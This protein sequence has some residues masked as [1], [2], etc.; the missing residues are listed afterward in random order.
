[1]EPVPLHRIGGRTCLSALAV[2]LVSC[3]S[4][5]SVRLEDFV[6]AYD[7][8]VCGIWTRCHLVSSQP[9]CVALVTAA[10]NGPVEFNS[11]AAAVAAVRAGKSRFEGVRAHACIKALESA[12]CDQTASEN[13]QGA[14]DG[15][16]VGELA[17]GN[18]CIADA[19][20]R[21]G[22]VCQ[23]ASGCAGVC[24]PLGTTCRDDLGCAR[25]EVCEADSMTCI[26]PAPPGSTG[27]PCGTNQTC[28]SGLFCS[29]TGNPGTCEPL[30][31]EGQA[32]SLLAC[33]QGL[34]C[35]MTNAFTWA[36]F[37]SKPLAKGDPCQTPGQCGGMI[38]SE[39][40]CDPNLRVCVDATIGGP[41]VPPIGS[42]DFEVYVG[43]SKSIR[44]GVGCNQ[45]TSYCDDATATCAA[46]AAFGDP[47]EV[48]LARAVRAD[49]A[50]PS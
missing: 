14:C 33:A 22:S 5:A 32:C 15:L 47:C 23:A 3:A 41:C 13:I 28:L 42:A 18:A 17:D 34:V 35:A 49:R 4:P 44:F 16:F 1:M 21:P 50:M 30:P 38:A 11:L 46:Y 26:K 20:C 40:T 9:Y 19:E 24:T 48:R 37:C 27:Q 36:G 25:D 43:G 31:T 29:D 39:N 8:A 6:A 10:Q 7:E 45:L 12:A 2:M